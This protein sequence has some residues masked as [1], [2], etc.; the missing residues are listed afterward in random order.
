MFGG[1]CY[2]YYDIGGISGKILV[3]SHF[4]LKDAKNSS[5]LDF[6]IIFNPYIVQK[7]AIY[8]NFHT[9]FGIF[10]SLPTF[11]K[12]QPWSSDQL[13]RLQ[14]D[15]VCGTPSKIAVFGDF[16][17]FFQIKY[18]QNDSCWGKCRFIFGM[19]F[20][21]PISKPFIVKSLIAFLEPK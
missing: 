5:F 2:L 11:M 7:E 3:W 4:S 6:L 14:N 10:F 17:A 8:P 19:I 20:F 9:L 15:V 16:W 18:L 1:N 13:L 12:I 21:F